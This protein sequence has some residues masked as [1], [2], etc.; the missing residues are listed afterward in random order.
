M[1]PR[2]SGD[3][4]LRALRTRPEL[5][6]VPVVMLTA[7]AD[8]ELRVRLLQEGAQDYVMKPFSAEELRA[9]VANLVTI[10]RARE[11]LQRELASQVRDLGV[12]ASEVTFRKQELRTALDAMRVARD[13]AERASRAKSDFLSLVSH[14]LCTPLTTMRT[15]L[16]VLERDSGSGLAPEHRAI[17]AKIGRSSTRLMGLIDSLL[18]YARIESGRLAAELA[19]VD[20]PALVSEVVEE[21]ETQAAEKGLALRGGVAG[22]L[23]PLVSDARLLRLILVNLIGNGIKYTERGSVSLSVSHAA[24][25]F[26]LAVKDSGPGIPVADQSRIFE[27]FEQLEPVRNK[28]TPG[29]GLGLAL[30]KQMV[31][32]LGG[33]LELCSE[34]DR[35]STFT[36]VL[37]EGDALGLR[38]SA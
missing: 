15:Y 25:R 34:P 2:A 10:K 37:P 14:E 18:E 32:A 9:R 20:L 3:E 13:Q 5:D 26:R 31:G 4:M 36:V 30:V 11:L 29:V 8:D 35:G 27:P 38:E 33:R 17:V 6:G 28:H 12:L 1:M 23:P 16:H 21:M 7:K 24:G 22:D 19:R